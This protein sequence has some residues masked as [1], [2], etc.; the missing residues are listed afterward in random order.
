MD[1]V[2]V[3]RV[4]VERFRYRPRFLTPKQTVQIIRRLVKHAA[5]SERGCIVWTGAINNSHYGRLSARLAG[6][7]TMLYTH[8]LAER[9]ARDPR[10]VPHWMEIAHSCDNPLCLH[11]DHVA[12][13]RRRTNRQKSGFNTQAKLRAKR[14]AEVRW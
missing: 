14:A 4:L 8:R 1:R 13:E 5:P 2:Q 11:P 7:H 12:R 3:I 6:G 10:D 9:L